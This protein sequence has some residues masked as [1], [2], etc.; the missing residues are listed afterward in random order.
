MV[1]S[2]NQ[3]YALLTYFLACLLACL[4][5]YD[6]FHIIPSMKFAEDK[7]K[8]PNFDLRSNVTFVA[9]FVW[10]KKLIISL[11]STGKILFI[12]L[13][14]PYS[15]HWIYKS[16][17]LPRENLEFVISRY[18][19]ITAVELMRLVKALIRILLT[20]RDKKRKIE[21]KKYRF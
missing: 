1:L 13:A 7:L 15:T 6:S 12:T 11:K 16:S 3:K 18:I 10:I 19:C 21:A 20:F 8:I 4:L 2:I 9:P 14:L 5:T 17:Y